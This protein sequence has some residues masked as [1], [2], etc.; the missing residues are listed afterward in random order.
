MFVKHGIG[1]VGYINRGCFADQD[2]IPRWPSRRYHY[3]F[4]FT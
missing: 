4:A 1:S 2:S 3:A